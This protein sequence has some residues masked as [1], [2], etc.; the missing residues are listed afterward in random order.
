MADLIV[1]TNQLGDFATNC[2]IVGNTKTREAI[3]IDPAD[4]A[5]YI[6]KCVL[7]T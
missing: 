2:Y 1:M 7:Q 6:Y 5:D 3:V 4:E